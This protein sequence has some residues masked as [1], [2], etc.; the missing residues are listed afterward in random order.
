[1]N[2]QCTQVNARPYFSFVIPVYNEEEHIASCLTSIF[3]SNYDSDKYEVIVVDNG[4]EDR[5]LEIAL[6]F[7]QAR[8]FELPQ[9][10]VG[11]VRNFGTAQALG[12]ILVFIDADCLVDSEWLTR[13]RD[14]INEHPKCA[15]GGGVKLPIDATWI[16]SSWLLEKQGKP[17]LPKHLIG[18][19]TVVSK[20]LFHSA[21][22]FNEEVSS[23]EDT[24]LH[25]RLIFA[26]ATVIIDHALN[27]THLGNAK[28]PMQFIRRQIWHSENYI[29]NLQQS[30]K[31]PIFLITLTFITLL[32][33]SATTIFFL[34]EKFTPYCILCA[35]LATPTLLSYKRMLRS[36]YVSFNPLTLI[37]IYFLD[38]LYL[39]GRSIGIIKSLFR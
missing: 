23:G 12:Q 8:V 30:L 22:G 17:T 5:S 7:K 4:S 27:V 29:S 13:A 39:S 19:S 6:T 15:Y 25:N 18:A 28:T 11:A 3:N 31:D 10:N 1:M 21:G 33:L 34:P 20:D 16:E 32:I 9:G 14:L 26:S 35:F 36:R 37:K 2:D 24:D 38:Y